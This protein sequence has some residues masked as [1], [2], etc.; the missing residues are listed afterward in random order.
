MDVVIDDLM[1]KF[2]A[3]KGL[4]DLSTDQ[5]FET[6]AA[7]CTVGQFHEDDFDADALRIGGPRDL[8]IDAAAIV[9]NGTLFTDLDDVKQYVAN[10]R[11]LRVH[12]VVV[13][14][15][16]KDFFEPSVLSSLATSLRQVFGPSDMTFNASENVK[17]LRA[18]IESI[19]ADPRKLTAEKP[20]LSVYYVTCGVPNA[21]ILE[22]RQ[23]DAIMEIHGLDRFAKVDFRSLGARQLQELY[24]R[25]SEAVSA[26]VTL[27]RRVQLPAIP[28]VDKAFIAAIPARDLVDK[29]LT[30]PLGDIRSIL[31]H[32]N[33][34]AFQGYDADSTGKKTGVNAEIRQTIRHDTSRHRFAVLNN[35]ITIVSRRVDYVGNEFVLRDFQIVNG[36]QTCYVMFDE[37]D[38]LDHDTYV[39]VRIIC[40]RDE[41]LISQ[42]AFATNRQINIT[43]ADL[44]S[45]DEFHKRL[46]AFFRAQPE[47]YK[48]FYERRSKQYVSEPVE[49]TRIVTRQQLM[50]AFAAM[51]LDEAHRVTRLTE[52]VDTRGDEMF[53]ETHDPLTYYTCA[54]VYYRIEWLLRN[55]K[56]NSTYSQARYHFIAGVKT[57]LLGPD[58]LPSGVRQRKAA[59]ERILE[60]IWNVERASALA[61]KLVR[62][63]LE[64]K[65]QE[66]RHARL[67]DAVRTA[68]F[69][70]NMLNGVMRLHDFRQAA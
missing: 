17:R 47:P 67:A 61:N 70:V 21:A 11:D 33:V 2:K 38:R 57:Y 56:L 27:D 30:D 53:R 15:K 32:E 45:R 62:P 29:V 28:G 8:G 66:G 44:S 46:E 51:Y 22:P 19:Y 55:G 31:F 58:P 48:L 65:E 7:Y 59:C 43:P 26:T 1:Q 49:K 69:R 34:R 14:A 13:Q 20:H 10:A 40:S 3:D 63:M 54:S 24:Q 64:A 42:V 16:A 6:F 37:R 5:L 36:C 12:F 39:T 41:E 60:E 52:L 68:R 23:N 25:A 4:S 50:K 35:G 9:V 18:C